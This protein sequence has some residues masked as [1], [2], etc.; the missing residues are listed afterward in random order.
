MGSVGS[1]HRIQEFLNTEVRVDNR[2]ISHPI[3]LLGLSQE[4]P[5]SLRK[6]ASSKA[7]E[8]ITNQSQLTLQSETLPDY[9]VSNAVVVQDGSFGW[10][11][12]TSPI[13]RSLSFTIPREKFTMIVGPVGC[14][15]STLIKALLG[16]AFS[17]GGAIQVSSPEIA[18]CDQTAWHMNVS[19]QQ[20]II[21]VS[22]M[23]AIWYKS[24]IHACAL[25]TDLKQFPQGDRT[26]IGSS[27]VALSGGQ[28]QRIVRVS[29]I[30]WNL[31]LH[32]ALGFS[33]SC[34]CSERYYFFG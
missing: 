16:E 26:V 25:E 20:S 18:F 13:L 21:G 12:D 33:K 34:I 15:K 29:L 6:S 27:G 3:D 22:K 9:P 24:V 7:S 14:G 19:I 2:K 8:S 1:F 32:A 17:M 5:Y 4:Y 10:D 23:D 31:D 28:S 11:K 30:T